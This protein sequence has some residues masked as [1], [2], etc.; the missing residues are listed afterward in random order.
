M[1]ATYV[2]IAKLVGA[3][4]ILS[5]FMNYH[6]RSLGYLNVKKGDFLFAVIVVIKF[7][8]G[9]ALIVLPGIKQ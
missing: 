6:K 5:A 4:F 7:M 9:L 3:V 8:V 2:L 1:S